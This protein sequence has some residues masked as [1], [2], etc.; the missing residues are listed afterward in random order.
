[1]TNRLTQFHLFPTDA[2]EYLAALAASMTVV[3]TGTRLGLP[4]FSTHAM[5]GGLVVAEYVSS[6]TNFVVVP[7]V[8]AANFA[9]RLAWPEFIGPPPVKS[10]LHLTE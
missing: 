9:A 3:S 1:M 8:D 7:N 2:T 10:E 5:N 4:L 6:R